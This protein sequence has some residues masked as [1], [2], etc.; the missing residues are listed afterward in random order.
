MRAGQIT[1]SGGPEVPDVVDVPEPGAGPGQKAYDV[2]TAG[3][4]YADT[5]HRLSRN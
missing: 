5:H 4:N 3:M 1:R 2:S